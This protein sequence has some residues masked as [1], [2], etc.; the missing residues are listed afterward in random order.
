VATASFVA[1]QTPWVFIRKRW[2]IGFVTLNFLTFKIIL[3]KKEAIVYKR[4]DFLG[5][6]QNGYKVF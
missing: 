1:C 3:K 2:P 6:R 5:P 4:Y